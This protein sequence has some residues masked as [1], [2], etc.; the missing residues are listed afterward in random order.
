MDYNNY[1]NFWRDFMDKKNQTFLNTKLLLIVC[2]VLLLAVIV[3]GAFAYQW[4]GENKD[5]KQRNSVLR[6]VSDTST[7]ESLSNESAN[8]RMELE[9]TKA[10][11]DS[12]KAKA[13]K[14]E[15]ILTENDLMPE[16]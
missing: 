13:E 6:A 10:E 9:S 4:H 15:T 12:Y 3:L 14:Y 16:E 2:A 8:L 11:R 7:L 5:L 1:S